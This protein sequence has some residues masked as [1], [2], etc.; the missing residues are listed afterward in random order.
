M[1]SRP[2]Q[3]RGARPL[4][5]PPAFE[6][7]HTV[8]PRAARPRAGVV[9]IKSA[10]GDVSSACSR[11]GAW[12]RATQATAPI[13]SVP[14][15][16]RRLCV[17][18]PRHPLPADQHQ[19]AEQ[20]GSGG[21]QAGVRAGQEQRLP[22]L[23][24]LSARA[25]ASG[26]C[27]RGRAA[28]GCAPADSGWPRARAGTQALACAGCCARRSRTPAGGQPRRWAGRPTAHHPAP[29]PAAAELGQGRVLG[30]SLRAAPRRH[31]RA[32]RGAAQ[33]AVGA[34]GGQ[35][36]ALPRPSSRTQAQQQGTGRRQGT[37]QRRGAG[38]AAGRKLSG[39]AQA[40]GGRAQA[41]GRA[42]AGGR[43]QAQRRGASQRQGTGRRQGASSAAGRKLSGGAQAS[44]GALAQRQGT[45]A[46]AGRKPAA[47]H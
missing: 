4:P 27:G 31:V 12:Q 2:S 16:L 28:Q 34:H 7:C 44:G 25:G 43:A 33:G 14:A 1:V 24:V 37:G 6:P 13:C 47:G 8:D 22:E 35:V 10:V 41:N 30:P 32:G 20:P 40:S 36:R 42:Q 17:P 29:A 11:V 19:A 15:A 3:R 9:T 26:G 38:P 5:R 46:A 21:H 18:T 39:G 23:Q 45:S